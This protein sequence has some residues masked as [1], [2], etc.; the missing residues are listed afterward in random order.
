M[1]KL[2]SGTSTK[3]WNTQQIKHNNKLLTI[4]CTLLVLS[5]LPRSYQNFFYSQAMQQFL[6]QKVWSVLGKMPARLTPGYNQT[7][8]LTPPLKGLSLTKEE[9]PPCFKQPVTNLGQGQLWNCSNLQNLHLDRNLF[10]TQNILSRSIL[11]AEMSLILHYFFLGESF[12]LQ[13]EIHFY[14]CIGDRS[15]R[16]RI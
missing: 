13:I 1:T 4:F 14:V 12:A 9:E 2:C 11:P 16:S 8:Q 3:L 7:I 6:A 5:L 15:R 10:S